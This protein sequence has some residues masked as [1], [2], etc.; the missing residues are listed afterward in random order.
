[1]IFKPGRWLGLVGTL[2]IASS[3]IAQW[4]LVSTSVT[5]P[6]S[7]R[8]W[9]FD[10]ARRLNVPAN[11]TVEVLA[12]V[13][14]ARF[15]AVAPNGDILVSQPWDGKVMLV[16][17]RTGQDPLYFTFASELNLPHDIVFHKIGEVTYVYIAETNRIA[18]YTYT[19]GNTT[20]VGRQV[21]VDN[22]PDSSLPELGGNY[23]HALKNIALD[24]NNKLYV[25]IASSSNAWPG[26]ATSNPVRCAIYRY[27]ADG[28]GREL[29]ARGIRNAEGLAMVPGTNDLWVAVNNRDNI[30]YPYDDATGW[31]GQEITEY[32]DNHPPDE[33]TKVIAG[34]NYGW[35]YANPNPSSRNGLDY[36]PFDPDYDNNR[37]WVNFAST[38]FRRISKG[39]PA[40][41]AA[42]GLTFW[43]S[44]AAPA[45]WR[46]G[47]SIAF[48]GSW[49]RS[50]R[51]GYK[52]VYFPWNAAAQSPLTQADLVTGWL[53]DSTQDIWGRPVDTAIDLDG[54]IL[55]SDD[56]SG[57]IYRLKYT[58]PTPNSSASGAI[59]L[60]AEPVNLDRNRA[61]DWRIWTS[62]KRRAGAPANGISDYGVIGETEVTEETGIRPLIY[63]G[64]DTRLRYHAAGVNKGFTF[65]TA[66]NGDWKTLRVFLGAKNATGKLTLKLSDSATEVVVRRKELPANFEGTATIRYR[67]SGP[68]QRLVVNWTVG[69]GAGSVFVQGAALVGDRR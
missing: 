8:W 50:Q 5:V 44:T 15:M 31:F 10:S 25:S 59:D 69:T 26:D 55:V 18:R 45:P 51:T 28:S 60:D 47:A 24:T 35:P 68:N 61:V 41:S 27:N 11:V 66:A 7:M 20:G 57:T 34:A 19:S 46:S 9:P 48:H 43:N 17:P 49:N 36:P 63:P 2:F 52:V 54:R 1:M 12:R 56:Y 38:T 64:G 39:L 65:S 21:V 58:P 33:F 37:S 53:N 13:G 6:T 22:L 3:A 42:L 4:D 30:R 29:F 14:G 16:R 32:I 23:G 40:H 62:K 67:A